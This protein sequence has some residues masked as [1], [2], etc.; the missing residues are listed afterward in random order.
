VVGTVGDRR[1]QR[2]IDL[3]LTLYDRCASTR[4]RLLMWSAMGEV[5]VDAPRRTA[6]QWGGALRPPAPKRKDT[7]ELVIEDAKPADPTRSPVTRAEA[8]RIVM[9]ALTQPVTPLEYEP[10]L[11]AGELDDGQLPEP[12][13][14]GWVVVMVAAVVV[15]TTWLLLAL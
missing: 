1:T 9:P 15:A 11:V 6:K 8:V 13:R 10:D 14:T 7:G 2:G 12:R 4:C 3:S 5:I